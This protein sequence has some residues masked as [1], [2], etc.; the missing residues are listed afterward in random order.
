MSGNVGLKNNNS[1]DLDFHIL[2]FGSTGGRQFV[3]FGIFL[4]LY[5]ICITWN[6]IIISLIFSDS[7]LQTPMYF[8]LRNLSIVD[9]TYTS[10]TVPKLLDIFL[11]GN[12]RISFM[13][14]FIQFFFFTAMACTEI[15]L[16]I[17]M[18]YDRYVAICKALH[19]TLVMNKRNC[20]LFVLGSWASGYS[21]SLFVTIVASKIYFCGSRFIDQLYCDIKPMLKI[22][23]GNTLTFQ[24]V[25]YFETFLMG[26][27]PFVCI[28]LSYLKIISNI[29]R[30]NAK[31]SRGKAFSTCTSHLIIIGIFYGT[32][33]I[34]YM[35]PST[36]DF[37][38]L[39]QV[40]SS[41]FL[42]VIPTIN[43]L[44]YSLRNTDIRRSFQKIV[45]F[46]YKGHW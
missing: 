20:N 44:I 1:L 18:A 45:N 31:G 21:N 39:D 25:V 37:K 23:C 42:A 10:V 33:F 4:L 5:L 14:C 3:L 30:V 26:L 43:P 34:V 2:A 11:T 28:T 40:A 22:S 9:I 41:F 15:V 16:L 36:A 46:F 7:R 24:A 35:M 17:A 6:S 19:Y 13:D 12:N 27:C 38:K 32:I 29:V 8:F